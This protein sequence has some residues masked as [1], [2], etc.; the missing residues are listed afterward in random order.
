[1]FSILLGKR[2]E[3]ESKH[4]TVRTVQTVRI[5][6]TRLSG[7]QNMDDLRDLAKGVF[8]LNWR[9]VTLLWKAL[10]EGFLI[11][12]HP[13]Y[14]L[15]ELY[16]YASVLA[17]RPYVVLLP[18]PR[19]SW[20][21]IVGGE[22]PDCLAVYAHRQL[23]CGILIHRLHPEGFLTAEVPEDR[24]TAVA[25]SLAFSGPDAFGKSKPRATLQHWLN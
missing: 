7:R 20:M 18:R 16:C 14:L 24:A 8:L 4:R 2:K 1:V 22:H 5:D 9:E 11:A 13:S 23:E 12:E 10:H 19:G 15:L 17:N 3:K 25:R 21:L 6:S